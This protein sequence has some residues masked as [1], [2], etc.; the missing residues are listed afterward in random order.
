MK[1]FGMLA[2]LF[3]SVLF[4]SGCGGKKLVCTMSE[5]EEGFK[6]DITATVEFDKN[7]IATK[8][9]IDTKAKFDDDASAELYYGIVKAAAES[10][11]GAKAKKS[12]KT[13][14]LVITQKASEDEKESRE[15]ILKGLEEEGYTCK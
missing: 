7:D 8:V 13:V 9:T 4:I 1:K 10:Q 11:K 2:V 15:E 12:G 6:A 5:E 3:V 14:S